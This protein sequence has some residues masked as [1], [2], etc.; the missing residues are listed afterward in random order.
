MR[1]TRWAF[2]AVSPWTARRYGRPIALL[3]SRQ[4]ELHALIRLTIRHGPRTLEELAK[5]VDNPSRGRVHG[6]L[7]R[8]RQLELVGTYGKR[9]RHGRTYLWIPRTTRALARSLAGARFP[10]RNDSPS[11]PSGTYLGAEWFVAAFE[12]GRI[13]YRGGAP[14]RTPRRR[15]GRR[16]VPQ[17]L[18]STCPIGHRVRLCRLSFSLSRTGE[19]LEGR[20]SATCRCGRVAAEHVMARA[21]QVPGRSLSAS[22]VADPEL[23]AR[24]V[25][26]AARFI[27][28]GLGL[29]PETLRSYPEADPGRRV[30]PRATLDPGRHSSKA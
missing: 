19:T 23:R 5:L 4:H 22:E 21:P 20:W 13:R 17:F 8:L 6:E 1:S 3:S 25:R 24:Y 12:T 16:S 2:P 15:D 14:P 18:W 26:Q 11:T 30:G 7:R 10:R 28:D 29:S 27:E 9:G